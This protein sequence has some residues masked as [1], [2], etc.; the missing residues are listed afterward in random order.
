MQPRTLAAPTVTLATA[1]APSPPPLPLAPPLHRYAK[2]GLPATALD[3]EGLD[4]V[5]G[6]A[7]I[8]AK[9][10]GLFFLLE[11]E[12]QARGSPALARSVARG[13]SPPRRTLAPPPS[14]LRFTRR[15]V[16]RCLGAGAQ[17]LR[18]GPGFEALRR[19]GQ[20]A[21][22]PAPRPQGQA[23][24]RRAPLRGR[25]HLRRRGLRGQE[26]GPLPRGPARAAAQLTQ[27]VRRGA[28]RRRRQR[29]VEKGRRRARQVHGGRR[30]VPGAADRAR[31]APRC[32]R[33]LLHPVHQAERA[34][35]A[36]HL[37]QGEGAGAAAGEIAISPSSSPRDHLHLSTRRHRHLCS[38]L[39]P[40]PATAPT[41]SSL[42]CCS[43]AP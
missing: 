33:L 37:Q 36:A 21:S 40:A 26:Q 31:D 8:D 39:C 35:A 6:R 29:P 3:F 16:A 11:E 17:G 12:C 15:A 2:E 1:P 19:G 7:L 5:K 28:H 27:P 25:G 38:L 41:R 13:A 24:L 10:S 32:V 20:E 34:A 30:Q 18:R 43:A 9:G 23:R 4:N 14:R 42:V 22:Q